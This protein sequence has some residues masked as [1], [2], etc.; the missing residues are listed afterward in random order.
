MALHGLDAVNS[1]PPVSL[2]ERPWEACLFTSCCS[3][4]KKQIHRPGTIRYFFSIN[5]LNLNF[6]SRIETRTLWKL[7]YKKKPSLGILSLLGL[8][9][10]SCHLLRQVK[11]ITPSL[12]RCWYASLIDLCAVSSPFDSHASFKSDWIRRPWGRH[13]FASVFSWDV[14]V[15]NWHVSGGR[16]AGAGWLQRSTI[17]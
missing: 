8:Q 13:N 12:Q 3:K 2:K 17:V 10:R 4:N 14:T 15:S 6:V 9:L 11:N 16:A 7:S 5:S 1:V